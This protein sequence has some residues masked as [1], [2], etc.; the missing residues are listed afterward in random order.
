M[1]WVDDMSDHTGSSLEATKSNEEAIAAGM[2][3][4]AIACV[5]MP[6]QAI[7]EPVAAGNLAS[8]SIAFKLGFIKVHFLHSLSSSLSVDCILKP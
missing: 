1:R 6:Q 7:A 5:H 2:L 3:N 8:R 4:L